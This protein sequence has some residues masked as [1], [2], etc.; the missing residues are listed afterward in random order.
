MG[1]VAQL[2]LTE[3]IVRC[4]TASRSSATLV[5]GRAI[6]SGYGRDLG[7]CM[8]MTVLALRSVGLADVARLDGGTQAWLAEGRSAGISA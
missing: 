3:Q 1:S 5:S 2:S 6:E 7:S 4:P 8:K